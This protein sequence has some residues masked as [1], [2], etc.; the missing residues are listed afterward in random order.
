MKRGH[1]VSA[2]PVL[3]LYEFVSNHLCRSVQ[4]TVMARVYRL[5]A[6]SQLQ[7]FAC[8]VK[9]LRELLAGV[10]LPQLSCQFSRPQELPL[11]TLLHFADHLP[12][13]HPRNV[14]VVSAMVNKQSLSEPL[15]EVYG[16]RASREVVLAQAEL[17]VLLASSCPAVTSNTLSHSPQTARPPTA[18]SSTSSRLASTILDSSAAEESRSGTPVPGRRTGVG[19]NKQVVTVQ[20][21]KLLLLETAEK[22]IYQLAMEA[23][24]KMEQGRGEE[25]E[26]EGEN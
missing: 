17:F 26:E 24:G 7:L 20:D 18:L 23:E 12:L 6:L 10:D 1:S 11:N 15:K 25:E 21:M 22:M 14:K 2:L 3:S 5:Q 9:L 4:H 8:A 16:M 13:D 19:R